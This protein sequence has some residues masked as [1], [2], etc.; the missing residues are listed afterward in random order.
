MLQYLHD[1]TQTQAA[2]YCITYACSLLIHTHTG[3]F[4]ADPFTHLPGGLDNEAALEEGVR[5]DLDKLVG[6]TAKLRVGVESYQEGNSS[7]DNTRWA[8]GNILA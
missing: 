5:R 3:E 7:A 1:T 4:D 6:E 8:P 2:T